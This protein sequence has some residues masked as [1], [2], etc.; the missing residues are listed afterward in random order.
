MNQFGLKNS[1]PLQEHLGLY[2]FRSRRIGSSSILN[3]KAILVASLE[4]SES[5]KRGNRIMSLGKLILVLSTYLFALNSSSSEMMG[6]NSFQ[7][8][9]FSN[10][11]IELIKGRDLVSHPLKK[12]LAAKAKHGFNLTVLNFRGTGWHQEHLLE[13]LRAVADTYLSDTCRIALQSA[14]VVTADPFKGIMD[15]DW[16]SVY[17]APPGAKDLV[18]AS[19]IPAEAPRPVVGL[20]R[21]SAQGSTAWAHPKGRAS[22]KTLPLKNFVWLMGRVNT[23]SYRSKIPVGYNP[24]AHELAHIFGNTGHNNDPENNI[25]HDDHNKVSTRI[26]DHQCISFLKSEVVFEL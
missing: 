24:L 6:K 20:M 4:S 25:L 5:G 12:E 19:A 18:L 23:E 15:I 7:E 10:V 8:A 2:F 22:G 17:P 26:L 11:E 1:Y 16:A 14:W 13:H 21:S 3:I 9:G